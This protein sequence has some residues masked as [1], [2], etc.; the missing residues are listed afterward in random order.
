[1]QIE[2]PAPSP[3]AMGSSRVGQKPMPD[4]LRVL[5]MVVNTHRGL[6]SEVKSFA[7]QTIAT[8][9]GLNEAFRSLTQNLGPRV[10]RIKSRAVQTIQV[11]NHPM[12]SGLPLSALEAV[13]RV[14][15]KP[16]PPIEG[17][18]TPEFPTVVFA[19]TE[20]SKP[21]SNPRKSGLP[22]GSG[23][24]SRAGTPRRLNRR[25]GQGLFRGY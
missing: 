15:Q 12:F 3:E 22:R 21:W 16:T 17:F 9:P 7:L 2:R 10:D 4:T 20:A 25:N 24:R 18:G 6:P 19:L 5:Q 14:A 11:E 13:L 1:M 23:S 8:S